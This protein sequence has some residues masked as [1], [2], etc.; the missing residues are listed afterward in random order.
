MKLKNQYKA[1]L[2]DISQT[3]QS[4]FVLD[5]DQVA[6]GVARS[7]LGSTFLKKYNEIIVL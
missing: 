1:A 7:V 4:P 5:P 6:L 3:D 2:L